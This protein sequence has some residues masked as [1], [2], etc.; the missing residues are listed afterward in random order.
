MLFTV[1]HKLHASRRAILHNF[2]SKKSILGLESMIQRK[3]DKL[4]Q[5]IKMAYQT[6]TVFH[7]DNAFAAIAS[8]VIGEYSYGFSLDYLDHEDFGNEV[9]DSMLST[10]ALSH[11]MIFFPIPLSVV[12][13]VPKR[14]LQKLSPAL[15]SILHLR[16]LV[17]QQANIALKDSVKGSS[18]KNTIFEALADP[19]LPSEERAPTRIRDEAMSLLNAGTETTAGA[20]RVIFFHLLNEK[21]K[22]LKL[23]NELEQLPSASLTELEGLPYMVRHTVLSFG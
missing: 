7:L 18:A 8:D 20:L 5:R 16:D 6:G 14:L 9:R 3:A 11:L 4:V 17:L 2:F 10:L 12:L 23:R 22:L 19:S 21:T 13:A 15:V 1:D